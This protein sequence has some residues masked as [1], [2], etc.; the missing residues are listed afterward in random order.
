VIQVVGGLG[1]LFT[2]YMAIQAQRNANFDLNQRY[3]RETAELFVKAV[4]SKSPEALYV[5]SYIA[6]RDQEHYQDTTIQLLISSIQ[7]ASR[8]SCQDNKYT[9]ADFVPD[10]KV[11]VA[12]RILAER[13]DRASSE[14]L[15]LEYSC[16]VGIDLRPQI[17]S[18]SRI[19][20]LSGTRMSGSRMLRVDFTDVDL[21]GAQLMGIESGDWRN[22]GWTEDIGRKLADTSDGSLRRRFVAHFSGA[23]LTDADFTGAGLEGADFQ[24]AVMTGAKFDGANLSRANFRHA[25]GLDVEKLLK[26]CVGSPDR[27]QSRMTDQPL[28]SEDDQS[29][30]IE[31]LRARGGVPICR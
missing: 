31:R 9:G 17:Q 21:I 25:K 28:L 12:L 20:G 7:T 27:A 26:A 3:D 13:R 6:R 11:Q 18:S 22:P 10:S 8:T 5:L 24:N 14:K 4:E 19:S 29:P 1:I 23:N 15:N 2:I 16:L 30:V